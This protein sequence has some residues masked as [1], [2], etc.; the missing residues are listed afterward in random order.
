MNR[1]IK[2]SINHIDNLKKDEL[3]N[4]YLSYSRLTKRNEIIMKYLEIKIMGDENEIK[5]KNN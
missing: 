3:E 1:H 4:L 5:K 2:E